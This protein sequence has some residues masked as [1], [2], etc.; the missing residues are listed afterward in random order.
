[1]DQIWRETRSDHAG[2]K[3]DIRVVPRADSRLLWALSK[4]GYEQINEMHLSVF[5]SLESR[6]RKSIKTVSLPRLGML[7]TDFFCLV[8]EIL[9]H[10]H[11]MI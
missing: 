3:E 6:S 11:Y 1:M 5:H 10:S 4:T 9:Q 7:S 8:Q 2:G